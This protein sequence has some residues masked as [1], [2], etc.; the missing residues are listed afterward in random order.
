MHPGACVRIGTAPAPPLPPLDTL[1]SIAP[2]SRPGSAAGASRPPPTTGPPLHCLASPHTAA[3]PGVSASGEPHPGS[4]ASS[5]VGSPIS[6]PFQYRPAHLTAPPAQGLPP[7]HAAPHPTQPRPLGR[8][9]VKMPL[10]QLPALLSPHARPLLDRALAK[11]QKSAAEVEMDL[12]LEQ[13]RRERRARMALASL[14][15]EPTPAAISASVEKEQLQEAACVA[16]LLARLHEERR[17]EQQVA[18]TGPTDS[19][20]VGAG[21]A[22]GVNGG[23][24]SSSPRLKAVTLPLIKWT[25]RCEIPGHVNDPLVCIADVRAPDGTPWEVNT[26]GAPGPHGQNLRGEEVTPHGRHRAF[27][28]RHGRAAR[29]DL[30]VL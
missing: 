17:I 13:A 8:V 18:H 12:F 3:L 9:P 23:G 4:H 11:R 25:L 20:G 10:V 27:V 26:A 15:V 22:S 19:G 21:G 14:G 1:I 7:P 29:E 24:C 5:Q 28:D 6:T 30:S 2:T 16:Y